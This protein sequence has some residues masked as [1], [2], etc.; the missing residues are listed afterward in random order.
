M[1]GTS[2]KSIYIEF[3]G[4]NKLGN[5]LKQIDSEATSLNGNLREINKNLKL[6]PGNT[7]VISQK[8]VY[9]RRE[10]DNVTE[11]LNILREAKQQA[12]RQLAN[13][14]AGTDQYKELETQ[15]KSLDAE[16]ERSERRLRNFQLEA[17][18][19]AQALGQQLKEAVNDL[20]EEFT[21][22]IDVIKKAEAALIALSAASVKTGAT[23]EQSMSE[24]AAVMA[25]DKTTE[26]YQRLEEAAR[27]AG[28]TTVYTASQSAEALR[29]LALAG[30][31]ADEAI[32]R[33]PKVLALAKAGSL[34]LYTASKIVTNSMASL[35][36]TE[37]ELDKLLDEMARTS[38][39]SNTNIA[40][41]G[42]AIKIV[43]GT[44]NM[45]G[46]PIETM[47]TQLGILANAGMTA[48]EAGTRLRNI[49]LSLAAPTDKAREAIDELGIS[50]TD[51][52]GNIR[53]LG[54]IL[55][56]I[57]EATKDMNNGE[58][59]ETFD[60]IFKL[61]D[62]TAINALLN[63]TT[64]EMQ[65]LREEIVNSQGAAQQMADTMTD[66]LLGDFTI[67]KSAIQELQIA[68]SE[69][70]T[71]VLRDATKYAQG[72]VGELTESAKSGE[73]AESFD[74]FGKALAELTK[75]GASLA[76]DIL[77]TLINGLTLIAEH[78]DD[79]LKIWVAMKAVEGIS[80]LVKGFKSLVT[81]VNTL[82]NLMTALSVMNP[83]GGL[84]A[85]TGV[86]V[87]SLTALTAALGVY[88]YKSEKAKDITG[89]LTK[90]AKE[91]AKANE[92]LLDSIESTNSARDE[93]ITKINAERRQYEELADRM[94]DLAESGK[95]TAAQQ[96]EMLGY[97]DELNKAIPD[98]NLQFDATTGKLSAQRDEVK[99]LIDA[100]SVYVQT[101]ARTEYGI[102]LA[103]QEI[104]LSNAQADA[105]EKAKE[106]QKK[107][108][109]LEEKK[110]REKERNYQLSQ[111]LDA[112]TFENYKEIADAYEKSS[113]NI[114]A[115]DQAIADAEEDIKKYT[116]IYDEN[117]EALKANQE[118]QEVNME[119]LEDL[120][121]DTV[122]NAINAKKM[123]GEAIAQATDSYSKETKAVEKNA[124]KTDDLKTKVS[125]YRSELTNL[126]GV[127]DNV[128]KG[129]A[130][131]TSQILDLIGKYPELASAIQY[132]TDGYIIQ[133]DAVA[134]LTKAKAED[135]IL[136]ARMQL[137]EAKVKE[138]AAR[139]GAALT[140]DTSTLSRVQNEVRNL[141][142]MITG[143]ERIANDIAS[144][145]YFSGSSSSRS[146]YTSSGS[147]GSSSSSERE[148]K[149]DYYK[150]QAEAEIDALE[151]EYKMGRLLAEE[152]YT[153]LDELNKKWYLNKYE[154]LDDYRKYEEK[155]YAGLE[156]I[157][158]D[159]VKAAKDLES[160]LVAVKKAQDELDNASSQKV[161]VY[162]SAAGYHA[163]VNSSAISKA[164]QTLFEK[165]QSLS[166]ILSK[167]ATLGGLNMAA[168]SANMLPN[169]RA[170]LP[171]LSG[172]R[173]P[174]QTG[175]NVTNNDKQIQIQYSPE[176]TI[177]GNATAEDVQRLK[178]TLEQQFNK[179]INDY[180]SKEYNSTLIGG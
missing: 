66:N 46:Q 142:S 67:L 121:N 118:A 39:R 48:G 42:E 110:N 136:T 135:M 98:L 176:I 35:Q 146:S 6:D 15:I 65:A 162:S 16:I 140:G 147:S 59:V 143:Y 149:T 138:V 120:S 81:V 84:V 72:L 151:H 54:D 21:G 9:L 94:F 26:E 160:S 100:Y 106:A 57:R 144:G 58:L 132:T 166:E 47:F 115:Y 85:S 104:E 70:F 165:Q 169:L 171:D 76:V 95:L 50:I 163:E 37:E 180:I 56:D 119:V 103:K 23:F 108:L 4:R 49:M 83:L 25:I 137:A 178:D 51:D 52:M 24:V 139:I 158:E 179:L 96:A 75:N 10:I 45:A 93:E 130:Y 102:E 71:P 69:H 174:S 44:M 129:T 116:E 170:L 159:R 156:K 148:D 101:A 173:L 73:L 41:L 131:S 145:R 109:E 36:L 175:G 17:R 82:K 99:N 154:Y 32:E 40:E 55:I 168:I 19:T 90:E 68:I 79:I 105:A 123:L 155:V 1:A 126:L 33:L 18:N 14:Q 86:L 157:Q 112:A 150:Q 111:Q 3:E 7:D 172:L 28:Q 60:T 164:Q 133:A 87:G 5:V 89:K 38:Q 64:G 88:I 80:A 107:S 31:T 34:D 63:G 91:Y 11:R 78:L 27:E 114:R 122:S 153:R 12:D 13:T 77:P 22:A 61:R 127:L 134:R 117:T 53:D 141:E 43:G 29:N 74:R 97:V 20:K 2:Y 62:L 167:T 128:N 152:Y 92:E 113:E 30:Y 8:F 161:K 125:N 124:E 177:Q